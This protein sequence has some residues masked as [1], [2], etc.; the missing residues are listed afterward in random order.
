MGLLEPAQQ[1]RQ[2]Q[3][4][5]GLRSLDGYEHPVGF[6]EIADGAIGVYLGSRVDDAQGGRRILA[7]HQ[8]A[9]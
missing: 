9:N 7:E 2:G 1:Q 8:V 6:T 5:T 4:A 3:H